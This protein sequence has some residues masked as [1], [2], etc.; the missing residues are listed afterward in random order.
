MDN[1]FN[2]SECNRNEDKVKIIMPGE[3]VIKT[4]DKSKENITEIN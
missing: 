4:K 1:G 2:C 3:T